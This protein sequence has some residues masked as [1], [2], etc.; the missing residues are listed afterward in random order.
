[1][2]MTVLVVE[3]EALIRA[4]AADVLEEAGFEVVKAS[5]GDDAVLVLNRRSDVIILFTDMEM[6]GRLNGLALAHF[7]REHHPGIRIMITSGRLRPKAGDMPA[8][9][10]FFEK[11]YAPDALICACQQL[12]NG[13]SVGVEALRP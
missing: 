13:N 4:F 11:P 5:S 2:T 6:P 8:D 7:V 12:M 9:A 3:D 1:M 10:I